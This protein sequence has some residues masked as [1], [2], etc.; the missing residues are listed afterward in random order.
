MTLPL[1]SH[2]IVSEA[3]YTESLL[4]ASPVLSV[5]AIRHPTVNLT[6][7][8]PQENGQYGQTVAIGGGIIVVGE[9]DAKVT[10]V[11]LAGAII[12]FFDSAGNLEAGIDSPNVTLGGQFGWSLAVGSG[13][14][15]VG[16]RGE[17]SDTG[18]SGRSGLPL[19]HKFAL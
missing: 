14:I 3:G 4:A 16:A 8:A 17:N 15:A 2:C 18:C 6:N 11:R 12:G 7:P 13:I 9:P 1:A 5:A 19:Q 10:N